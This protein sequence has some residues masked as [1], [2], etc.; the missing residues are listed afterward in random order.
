MPIAP[1]NGINLYYEAEGTG[2]PLIFLPGLGGTTDLWKYQLRHFQNDYLTISLDNRGAGRS[3]KPAGPYSMQLFA[4]DLLA[5]LDFMGI[6]GPVNLVGASMGGLISQSFV[7]AYPQRVKKLALVCT[8][9]SVADPHVTLPAPEVM[10]RLANPG[11]TPEARVDTLLESFYHPDFV[12]AHP[13]LK[14]WYLQRKTEAQPAHA[15]QA[16]LATCADPRPYYAWLQ[17]IAIPVLVMHGRDD[18]ISPVQNAMTLAEGLGSKG[19]LAIIENAAHV[20]M[21]EKPEEFNGVLE[22]FL[23]KVS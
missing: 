11:T 22:A 9:V 16:Q 5:L 23:R 6:S 12:R 10:Q 14:E 1:V 17:E 18:R 7:H 20:F 4:S 21:Q 15:Y 8:S 3:D 13:E 19:T 2:E